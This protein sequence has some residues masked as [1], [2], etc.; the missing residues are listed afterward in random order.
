MKPLSSCSHKP[1]HLG[2]G[3]SQMANHH[4]RDVPVM[5]GRKWYS[6]KKD[7]RPFITGTSNGNIDN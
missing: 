4:K 1:A 2:T 6:L 7:L 5:K 3:S